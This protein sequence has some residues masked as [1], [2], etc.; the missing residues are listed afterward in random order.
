MT[1]HINPQVYARA[2][3]FTDGAITDDILRQ[4]AHENGLPLYLEESSDEQL[5]R[6]LMAEKA[7][8]EWL[9]DARRSV[10]V[11]EENLRKARLPL[12][13]GWEPSEYLIE[14]AERHLLSVRRDVGRHEAALAEARETINALTKK[15]AA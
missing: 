7:T 9:S 13:P 8:L 6:A 12:R 2:E 1:Q 14:Q 4:V 10:T 3:L 5:R 11:S 15:E